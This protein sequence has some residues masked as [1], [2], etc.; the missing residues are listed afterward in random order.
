VAAAVILPSNYSFDG[1]NDS[2]KI[3]EKKR[4]HLSKQILTQAL[5]WSIAY[6]DVNEIDNLNILRATM[7]AMRRS[8]LGLA[9]L[10]NLL[11]IDGNILP[12]LNFYN[13]VIPGEAII[14]GDSKVE[15]I[16]AASII[17]KVYRD[18]LMSNLDS[19][20]PGY[21]FS[22]HKGYGTKEHIERIKNNG[23]SSQHR[24]SFRPLCENIILEKN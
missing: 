24:M 1:L 17:A 2:K 8:I 3:S 23:P 7:L 6:S 5:S 14:G 10:P 4:N 19:F 11:R 9:Y 13:K 15:E 16:S 20:Y 18:A 22:K 21:N 12:N